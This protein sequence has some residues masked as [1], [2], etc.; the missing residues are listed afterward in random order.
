[1]Y[2]SGLILII[3]TFITGCSTVGSSFANG[4]QLKQG[5]TGMY[6][7][8]DYYLIEGRAVSPTISL[9]GVPVGNIT[10][11]AYFFIKTR[12]GHHTLQVSNKIFFNDN[13]SKIA[14]TIKPGQINYY[15]VNV[16][17]GENFAPN[18]PNGKIV[19]TNTP[20]QQALSDL[21]KLNYSR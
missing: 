3:F 7:Y 15:K 5:N 9:D 4:P 16:V 19:F 10:N 17:Y 14:V 11:G 18:I 13:G 1:M 12:P 20:R 8:R 2:K 21:S 6:I